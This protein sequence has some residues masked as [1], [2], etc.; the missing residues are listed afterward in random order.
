[1]KSILVKDHT[2]LF[3][4]SFVYEFK[5]Q[6]SSKTTRGKK[7][8]PK[9]RH[10]R[11]HQ[12]QQGKQLFLPYRWSSAC[13]T[14]NIYF[15]IFFYISNKY[16]DKQRHTTSKFTKEPKQK[17]RLGTASDKITGRL[18]LVCGRPTLALRSA[19]VPQTLSCSVC[20]D[21]W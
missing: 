5:S 18:Q 3:N 19:L 16:N 20:V 4:H 13:L 17:S 9:R 8:S 2:R 14:F 10:Q 12:R 11:Q 1:M 15:Y 21:D 7:D 6:I